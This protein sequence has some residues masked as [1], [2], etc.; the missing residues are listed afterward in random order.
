MFALDFLLAAAA[1]A[2][3]SA[4][5]QRTSSAPVPNVE[6]VGPTRPNRVICRTIIPS[7]SHIAA[8]RICQTVAQADAARDRMQDEAQD[9]VEST[10]RRTGEFLERSGYGNWLRANGFANSPGESHLPN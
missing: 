3:V 1:Q 10:M 4:P 7:G 8:R 2:A 5:T 9:D 6:V